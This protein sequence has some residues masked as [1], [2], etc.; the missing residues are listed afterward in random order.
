MKWLKMLKIEYV[1]SYVFGLVLIDLLLGLN[2][3]GFRWVSNFF[4]FVFRQASRDKSPLF[5][6]QLFKFICPF[7]YLV[8]IFN[9]IYD[10]RIL[11]SSGLKRF[12]NFIWAS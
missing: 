11:I 1:D 7:R 9:R 6:V 4:N 8:V 2:T 10:F 12:R 5:A 3:V